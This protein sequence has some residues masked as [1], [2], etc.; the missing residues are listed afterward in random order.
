[1]ETTFGCSV[2][3]PQ[4]PKE[5]IKRIDTDLGTEKELYCF[6]CLL[7]VKDPA[8]LVNQLK[9]IEEFLDLS[10][11]FY[12]SS[13]LKIVES[14]EM[15]EEYLEIFT[16]EAENL[17]F[18]SRKVE[19]EK[20]LVQFKFDEITKDFVKM[21]NKKRDEM[22]VLLDK[23]LFNYRYGYVYLEKQ[24]RKAFPKA[25]DSTLYPS[26][27]ELA[28]KLSQITDPT[29]MMAFIKSIKDDMNEA[30]RSKCTD[31]ENPTNEDP[32]LALIKSLCTKLED[33]KSKTPT[34]INPSADI[35]KAREKLQDSLAKM[36]DEVFE[37]QNEIEDLSG[38]DLFPKSSLAKANDFA[39][40]KKWLDKE[41]R[42]R[43]WKLVFKGT[44]DGMTSTAF[45]EKA[46]NKGPTIT[47]IKSKHG[48]IF[49]GFMDQAWT[50]RGGYINTKKSWLFSL[51]NKSKYEM[52]DPNTYAQYGGYDN[53]SY[54]PT[55][56]G[57]HDIYLAND[58][59][60]NSNYCNRH[61]YNFTDNTALT[62]GYN[63]QVE[64]VEVFSLDKK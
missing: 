34:I 43:K 13:R 1:M 44:K 20:K 25:E 24:L 27:E 46:N 59:T 38:G 3:C 64:E 53:S 60:S 40:M 8:Q 21:I 61:S 63:F 9:P 2:V 7:K 37:L 55:F 19:D 62:G 47:I 58:F 17:E 35:A 42:T 26:R 16:K 52:N 45:H 49:G 32:R 50:T 33:I 18:L 28:N 23:Q 29:E 4:H 12:D 10:G 31:T 15:P 36:F 57:G 14:V 11:R 5:Y 48:K 39:Q 56:G 30:E 22:F 51:T 54:G 6:E 41:Y